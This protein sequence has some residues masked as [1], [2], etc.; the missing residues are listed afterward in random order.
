MGDIEDKTTW[1]VCTA[2]N[3]PT[4]QSHRGAKLCYVCQRN[5]VQF[6]AANTA[7]LAYQAKLKATLMKVQQLRTGGGQPVEWNHLAPAPTP[8]APLDADT[9]TSL[10][11]LVH[12][13][14]HPE[15][16]KDACTEMTTMLLQMRDKGTS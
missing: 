5:G 3:M 12:P 4:P 1:T 7:I 11:K 8:A 10:L 13:D 14:V 15:G 2:C 16:R 9:I 6:N